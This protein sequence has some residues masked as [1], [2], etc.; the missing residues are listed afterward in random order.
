MKIENFVVGGLGTN[1]Y[2]L[3]HDE[4]KEIIIVDPA[5]FSRQMRDYV[6][7][8]G[9]VPKAI[10]L[11]HAHFDHTMGI[12]KCVEAYN[13]PVYLYEEEEDLL[14][15]P[16]LN[17]SSK[18]G[19]GYSYDG[20]LGLAD[21]KEVELA[22][23]RFQVIHTPG[24]T[25]GSCCYYFAD[26]GVLISGDTLFAQSVGRT[27]FPTGS[28]SQLVRS[29]RERLMILP[30]RVEVYPGHGETTTIGF[31]KGHNPFI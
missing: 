23:M 8:N 18:F 10:L 1:C 28:M 14:R 7:E 4:T 26:D 15:D 11:T 25:K 19:L 13:I 3:V 27:D 9:Y 6:S 21:N 12:D 24:H 31:E 20:A 5:S 22:G 29:I 16:N 2:L 17:L 30:E